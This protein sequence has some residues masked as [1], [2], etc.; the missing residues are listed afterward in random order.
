MT[1]IQFTALPCGARVDDDHPFPRVELRSTRGYRPTPHW[2]RVK[3]YCPILWMPC[4]QTASTG[5]DNNY[6]PWRLVYFH[7]SLRLRQKRLFICHAFDVAVEE[8][9]IALG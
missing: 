8:H 4:D 9:V 6:S 5:L 1:R 2:G 7:H 3:R